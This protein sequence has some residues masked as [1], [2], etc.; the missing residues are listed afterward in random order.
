MHRFTILALLL[1][2]TASVAGAQAP[3]D[4][5]EV[6]LA[7]PSPTSAGAG[8]TVTYTIGLTSG[9]DVTG[10][11]VTVT[12]PIPAST[13]FSSA[14]PSVGT[15][16]DPPDASSDLT[17]DIPLP[18]AA[19][20][21]VEV[22]IPQDGCTTTSS[23]AQA[24]ASGS[25]TVTDPMT[26][27]TSTVSCSDT[28]PS[29]ALT[30]ESTVDF[31]VTASAFQTDL[32]VGDTPTFQIRVTNFGGATTDPVS[33]MLEAPLPDQLTFMS[34]ASTQAACAVNPGAGDNGEDVVVCI[35]DPV[36]AGSFL[37][38]F[39][40]MNAV[41]SGDPV[42]QA[43]DVVPLETTDLDCNATND[44]ASVDVTISPNADLEVV[45]A[46]DGPDPSFAGDTLTYT[47]TLLNNGPG[48]AADGT[49]SVEVPTDTGFV[50]SDPDGC[51]LSGTTVSCALD[52]LASQDTTTV[53]IQITPDPSARGTFTSTATVS[54]ADT[55]TDGDASNDSATIDTTLEGL[56]DLSFTLTVDPDPLAAGGTAV[57]TLA[58]NNAGPSSAL[59]VVAEITLPD[60][61]TFGES[62]APGTVSIDP[63]MIFEENF[64]SGAIGDWTG[65]AGAL[66][67]TEC[68]ASGQVVTCTVDEIA[69]GSPVTITFSA[70]VDSSVS[71]DVETT[72]TVDSDDTDATPD[73]N[74]GSTTTG[75]T[76]DLVDLTIEVDD[77]PDP[78][79]VG[80]TLTYTLTVT[81]NGSADA[82][83]T[84]LD[85]F[86]PLDTTLTSST[87]SP[88]GSCTGSEPVSC[89]IGD[90]ASGGGTATVTFE[91]TVSAEAAPFIS[92]N[93]LVTADQVDANT[94]D[95]RVV[96][97]TEVN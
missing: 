73:D 83:G 95:D 63:R 37:T 78:V 74:T 11:D 39:L 29:V 53:E 50:S 41:D 70:D 90:V 25:C 84:T 89:E 44:D 80:G 69:P 62:P 14:T 79:S 7:D 45:S 35:L 26:G 40:Q 10:G 65:T 81:N 96:E 97:D 47:I 21:A 6:T 61:V 48:T 28:S 9:A 91:T 4:G 87:V 88:S 56:A 38:L 5:I 57:Y 2:A 94:G 67:V 30:I 93:A 1:A 16:T 36:A 42:T 72:V 13:E 51:M 59:N 64:E 17:C 12:F 82:T 60:G 52:D 92:L 71:G 8:D 15:C 85:A 49:L 68:T 27:T 24:T 18:A 58:L 55:N 19:T 77:S 66:G 33:G 31:G 3:D 43:F 76:R 54:L 34:A 75:S 86:L 22:T 23:N 32:S 46:T 20:I